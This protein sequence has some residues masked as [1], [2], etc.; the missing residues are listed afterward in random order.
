MK[1]RVL[2]LFVVLW[3]VFQP[4]LGAQ[5]TTPCVG[6]DCDHGPV[7][8]GY[9]QGLQKTNQQQQQEIKKLKHSIADLK[10]KTHVTAGLLVTTWGH[11]FS[12]WLMLNLKSLKKTLL[13]QKELGG[14]SGLIIMLSGVLFW[15][16]LV[17]S[18]V[19]S[20]LYR[21]CKNAHEAR[22]MAKQRSKEEL[23]DDE[24]DYLATDEAIPVKMNLVQAY[25]QMEDFVSAK[26]VLDEIMKQ[27]D[28]QQREDASLMYAKLS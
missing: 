9:F 20:E 7:L 27:G 11:Q 1:K 18:V 8:S 5:G 6:Y 2:G 26:T 14:I 13:I 17:W 24:Y 25:I 15:C 28:F 22:R 10:L 19:G 12:D 16:F 21:G 4:A 3:F 23:T